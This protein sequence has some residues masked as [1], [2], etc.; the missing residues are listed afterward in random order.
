[1]FSRKPLSFPKSSTQQGFSLLEV[2]ISILV[3]SF[4]I[5]GMAGL[6]A[7]S[8][9]VGR[10]SRLQ[11]SAVRYAEEMAELMRSNKDVALKPSNPYKFSFNKLTDTN[12]DTG[13]CGYPT[14]SSG[15]ATTD[16]IA[17]R[18]NYEWLERLNNEL[19]DARVEICEDST[20]Y[21]GNGL[22]QWTCSGS[23]GTLVIKIGWTRRNTLSGATGTDATST[24]SA[25]RKSVV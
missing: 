20:P 9:Q 23:G 3:L 2:L 16:L 8:L 6:Q 1:M 25:D 24:A 7:A 4:G 10:E 12:T 13:D 5:L 15:C 21:D 19:P 17:N 18:D 11:A 22:P 14:S